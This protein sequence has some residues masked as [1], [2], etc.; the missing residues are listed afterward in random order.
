MSKMAQR[1]ACHACLLTLLLAPAIEPAELTANSE[2]AQRRGSSHVG[3]ADEV[4]ASPDM[5]SESAHAVSSWLAGTEM[6]LPCTA[7]V[8]QAVR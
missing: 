4:L 2:L 6:G 7:N 5:Q 1:V 3:S 8:T